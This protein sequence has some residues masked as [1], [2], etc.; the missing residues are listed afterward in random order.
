MNEIRLK[1]I[2]AD[3]INH[4]ETVNEEVEKSIRTDMNDMCVSVI[5]EKRKYLKGYGF[6]TRDVNRAFFYVPGM[7][8]K[9]IT[10]GTIYNSDW[11]LSRS[12][13]GADK[14]IQDNISYIIAQG[15][16]SGKDTY[17]IAKDLEKY[18][19][20][21]AR[22]R[23]RVI[24]FQK[25]KRNSSGKILRD[26]SGS[27]I[28]DGRSR[29]FYFGNVDYNAQRLARTMISH[30][31]Q[32]SFERVNEKDPFVECYIWH[33][34]GL[35]GRTCKICLDRDGEKFKKDELPLDHPNGM[36]TFEAY[37][38][39]TDKQIDD[40]INRWYSAPHGTYPDIDEYAAMFL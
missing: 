27:P 23:S 29:H 35:H 21:S 38:S 20:P 8:V 12:I 25:Y 4:L 14:K 28:P 6:K 9:S 3:V 10:S 1:Q 31:Y 39:Y 37:I 16:A 22:K 5:E 34:A 7:V 11:T 36:C 15:V 24:E 30:A 18:V 26:E 17:S 2:R 19:N 32:Q 13:W 33:S 40:M